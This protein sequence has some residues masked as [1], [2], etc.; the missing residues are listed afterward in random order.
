MRPVD[1]A[2]LAV[3]A[4]LRRSWRG[5]LALA[6][7]GG[8]GLGIALA[9]LAGARRTESAFDRFLAQSNPGQVEIGIGEDV[10]PAERLEL[11][12]RVRALPQ[13]ERSAAGAWVFHTSP[14]GTRDD[15]L[16]M[17]ALDEGFGRDIRRPRVVDGRLP[18][19]G[20]ADEVLLNEQASESLDLGPGDT[21][22]L[23]GVP[24]EQA[25]LFFTDE[26]IDGEVRTFTIVGVARLPEDLEAVQGNR[27]AFFTPAYWD[28]VK[29]E[30][31][32][33]GPAL[34]V[35]VEPGQEAAFADAV[36]EF[37][38]PSAVDNVANVNDVNV[39]DA[40]RVQGVALRLF[41]IVVGIATV[42]FLGLGFSRQSRTAEEDTRPL[43][44]L[45]MARAGRGLV[46]AAPLVAAALVSGLLAAVVAVGL[47]PLFPF[48]LAGRAEPDRGRELDAT[49]VLGGAVVLTLLLVAVAGA[50]ATLRVRRLPVERT[51]SER[52]F[53]L[54]LVAGLGVALALR[55][56]RGARTTPVRSVIATGVIAVTLVVATATFGYSLDRLV[57]EPP[58]YGWN[59]D[60]IFGTSDDPDTFA[61][62]APMLEADERVGEWAVASVVDL[63][64]GDVSV[65]VMGIDSQVGEIGPVV[66]EGRAPSGPGEIALGRETLGQ[67]GRHVGDR[68]EMAPIDGGPATELSIVGMSVFPAGDHDFPGALGEGGVMTL[69]ALRQVGEAPR[70]VYLVR[71]AEQLD[72][73]AVL[74]DLQGQ[75]PGNYGPASDPEIDNL[76]Q[77]SAVIPALVA[78]IAVV[79]V[80]ALGHALVATVRRRRHDLALFGSLGMR[81]R[82]LTAVVLVQAVAI[83]V[84]AV[85]LGAPLGL[86]VARSAWGPVARGLGVADDIAVAAPWGLA[87]LVLGVL[88]TVLV[89][90]T[91][92]ALAAAR[93]RPADALRAE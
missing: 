47:S 81:P 17:V 35:D 8:L 79:A 68:I 61:R 42:T 91:G 93:T 21:L 1:D 29:D 66:I 45:G 40:T 56:G 85:A 27:T 14:D 41:A 63:A 88:L 49:V 51:S 87:A 59:V 48:G 31:A 44:A 64:A 19:P 22:D 46:V 83:G 16:P 70:H 34:L 11:V 50:L 78:A 36:A 84:I 71:V 69:A 55:P 60:V 9:C 25:D 13:V 33:F 52:P 26:P 58:R 62:T 38:P 80:I 39:N 73:D 23:V 90:A 28:E 43:R 12:E 18:D 4:R 74:S 77:A 65:P 53:P 86:V 30:L 5:V 89:L 67:L 82:Q 7:L 3:R 2:R 32:Y 92:P 72:P 20:R 37:L 75:G 6:V 15:V 24:A 57:S 76:D 10:P 54:P